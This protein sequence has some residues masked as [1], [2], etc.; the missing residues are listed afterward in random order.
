MTDRAE[1]YRIYWGDI[2]RSTTASGGKAAMEEHFK[3]ARE[4]LHLDFFAIADNAK[5][6]EDPL[7]HRFFMEG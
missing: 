2:H 6:T 1:N 4:E 3:V 7:K 5:L